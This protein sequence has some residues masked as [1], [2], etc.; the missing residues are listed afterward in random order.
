MVPW[1]GRVRPRARVAGC[2]ARRGRLVVVRSSPIRLAL[3]LVLRAL[4]LTSA[5]ACVACCQGVGPR[6]C[7]SIEKKI[8]R[9]PD[10]AFHQVWLEPEGL[11]THTVYPSGI[12][13]ALPPEVQVEMLRS[14]KGL[15]NVDMVRGP[16]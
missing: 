2:L 5:P 11:D 7:P 10:K 8:I 13:T 1:Q 12:N 4:V 15:E 9:F 3:A 14:M 16:L 6:Y